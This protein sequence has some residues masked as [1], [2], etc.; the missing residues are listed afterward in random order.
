MLKAVFHFSTLVFHLDACKTSN[1]NVKMFLSE[2][3]MPIL[4]KGIRDIIYTTG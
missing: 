2:G 3:V 1:V 4:D